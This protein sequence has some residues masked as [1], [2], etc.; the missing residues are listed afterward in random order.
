VRETT[1]YFLEGVGDAFGKLM[2]K[3]SMTQMIQ[4]IIETGFIIAAESNEEYED[5]QDSPHSVAMYMLHN[6][7]TEIPNETIYPIFK[8]LIL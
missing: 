4:Q 3:K 1:I 7:A 8:Q 6:Y 2:A 5:D